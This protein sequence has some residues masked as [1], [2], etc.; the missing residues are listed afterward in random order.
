MTFETSAGK[1]KETFL[2]NVFLAQ[3]TKV[4]IKILFRYNNSPVCIL[5]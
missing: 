5:R 2:L 4:R 3:D 1:K